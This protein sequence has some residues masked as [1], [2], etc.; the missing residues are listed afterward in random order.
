M[1]GSQGRCPG[2][3]LR[4]P[5]LVLCVDGVVLIFPSPFGLHQTWLMAINLVLEGSD[6]GVFK[7]GLDQA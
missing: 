3:V 1:S 2:G 4:L 7:E 6:S 5:L